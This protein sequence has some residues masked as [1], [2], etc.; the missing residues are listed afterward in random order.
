MAKGRKTGG[1]DWQKGKS[2]N[3]NPKTVPTELKLIRLLTAKE[4]CHMAGTLLYSNQAEINRIRND[5]NEPH[6]HR[7]IAEALED[8]RA[9]KSFFLLNHVL[10]RV[11][12]RPKEAPENPAEDES[13]N[14]REVLE[15]IKKVIHDPRNER[16]A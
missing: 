8:A 16:K 6:I 3:P 2:G 4:F 13:R 10:D 12:G 14:E 11:L 15:E 9:K 5:E 1:R 7:I